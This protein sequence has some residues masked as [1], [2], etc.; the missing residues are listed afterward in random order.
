VISEWKIGIA[1][2]PVLIVVM[3]VLMRRQRVI[4]RQHMAIVIV[5]TLFIAAIFLTM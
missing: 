1:V 5:A 4:S 2:A 3:A